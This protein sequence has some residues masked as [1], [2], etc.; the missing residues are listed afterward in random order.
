MFV[1]KYAFSYNGGTLVV[2]NGVVYFKSFAKKQHLSESANQLNCCEYLLAMSWWAYSDYNAAVG[3]MVQEYR[4][5]LHLKCLYIFDTYLCSFLVNGT[6][7][8]VLFCLSFI[9]SETV[10]VLLIK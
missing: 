8:H 7:G 4:G 10:Q 5:K 9:S 2:L 3:F 1:K 6:C